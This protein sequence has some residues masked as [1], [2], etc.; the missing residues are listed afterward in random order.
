VFGAY[1]N[2]Y[3]GSLQNDYGYWLMDAT[4]TWTGD[5]LTA[6]TTGKYL[7]RYKM[8]NI[9]NGEMLGT[10]NTTDSVWQAVNAGVYDGAPLAWSGDVTADQNDNGF[11]YG[12]GLYSYDY[13][14][15]G[16]GWLDIEGDS[17]GIMGYTASLWSDP[18]FK[19]MGTYNVSS[20]IAVGPPYLWTPEINVWGTVTAST[21][22]YQ[23]FI[24]GVWKAD[25]TIDANVYSLYID[26]S[27]NGGI[28]KGTVAGAYYPQLNMFEASG[29]W[30]PTALT[31]GLDVTTASVNIVPT[32]Y[33]YNIT[34]L[35]DFN[36]AGNITVAADEMFSADKWMYSIN[37]QDWG[38]EK[39]IIGGDYTGPTSDTWS[40]STFVDLSSQGTIYGTM[41]ESNGTVIDGAPTQWSNGVLLGKTYGYGADIT[42]TPMT[43]ISVGETVGTFDAAALSWQAV[44]TGAWL[45]TNKFLAMTQT[46]E[47]QAALT[48]LNIPFAEVGRAN[49]SGSG[50]MG[51]APIN[52]NMQCER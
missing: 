36:G 47:G 18:N 10:Y 25:G 19:I 15:V 27:G 11:V 7:T 41:T 34:S 16:N 17:T 28:L 13:Y 40:L 37:G 51:G 2:S 42:N 24:G 22:A 9:I 48:A 23:G 32:N 6:T 33:G 44:Q 38:I 26:P 1:Y 12:A 20:G 50:T 4:G 46:A 49:L 21:G 45:E 30:T 8:G 14:G 3:Y 52:V 43:W 39:S 31:F 35:G 29:T 5:K